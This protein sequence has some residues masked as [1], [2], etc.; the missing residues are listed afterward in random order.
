MGRMAER[1]ITLLQRLAFPTNR[2]DKSRVVN[3]WPDGTT[4]HS[5]HYR[6]SCGMMAS[7]VWGG[8]ESGLAAL[9]DESF[10]FFEKSTVGQSRKEEG[11]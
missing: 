9:L 11:R 6:G 10:L 5:R 8:R 3:A 4:E 1:E 2:A 7:F